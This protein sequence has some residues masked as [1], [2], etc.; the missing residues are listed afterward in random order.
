MYQP[1]MATPTGRYGA[2][3]WLPPLPSPVRH[4][5]HTRRPI[6]V[7][8][9]SVAATELAER[10]VRSSG[11]RSWTPWRSLTPATRCSVIRVNTPHRI[12]RPEAP[13]SRHPS[14]PSTLSTAGVGNST[15]PVAMAGDGLR[16][17][18][19]RM[20]SKWLR[21]LLEIQGRRRRRHWEQH[22]PHVMATCT[23]LSCLAGDGLR[24]SR[25]VSK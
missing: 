17:R 19:S 10:L 15:S 12:P 21:R 25:M 13:A 5:M 11:S 24:S 1:T 3:P 6:E 2:R 22:F 7:R 8:A 9:Q 16:S 14:R 18:S 23:G 4:R 20:V